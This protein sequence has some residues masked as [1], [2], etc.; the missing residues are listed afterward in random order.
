MHILQC[1]TLRAHRHPQTDTYSPIVG[2]V[3]VGHPDSLRP[4][5][6]LSKLPDSFKLFRLTELSQL[7]GVW[8]LL[9]RY[10]YF[11]F[12]DFQLDKLSQFFE[13]IHFFNKS[14]NSLSSLSSLGSLSSEFVKLIQLFGLFQISHSD[15]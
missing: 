1:S 6:V 12:W 14:L 3:Y 5:P 15:V 9:S 8:Y 7:S 4:I 11:I 13:Q 10:I 2:S